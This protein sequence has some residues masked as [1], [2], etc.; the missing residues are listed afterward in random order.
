MEVI[1]KQVVEKDLAISKLNQS[2]QTKDRSI[3]DLQ[4]QLQIVSSARDDANALK[5]MQASFISQI[6]QLEGQ[7]SS[8]KAQSAKEKA[9]QK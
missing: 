6:E 8:L 7:L 4:N 9:D 3:Q 1:Q 5:Q 2:I